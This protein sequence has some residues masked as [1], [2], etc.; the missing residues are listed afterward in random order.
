MVKAKRH[1]THQPKTKSQ[2]NHSIYRLSYNQISVRTQLLWKTALW[3]LVLWPKSM[4]TKGVQICVYLCMWDLW[5]KTV[6]F[7]LDL[8][9]ASPLSDQSGDS[10]PSAGSASPASGQTPALSALPCKQ[11]V[12]GQNS[13]KMNEWSVNM[14]IDAPQ[15]YK[16]VF[17]FTF[18]ANWNSMSMSSLWHKAKVDTNTHACLPIHTNTLI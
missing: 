1:F 11:K 15:T 6:P 13:V 12:Q 2:N 17:L 8:F 9:S 4:W 7:L 16:S 14:I 10:P 18:N 3:H 5:D